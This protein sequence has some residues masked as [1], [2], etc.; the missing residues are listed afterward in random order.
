[1]G[2]VH[3]FAELDALRTERNSAIGEAKLWLR[4]LGGMQSE[5]DQASADLHAADKCLS[6]WQEAHAAQ[7]AHA[8]DLYA[9]IER[10]SDEV[11]ALQTRAVI[12]EAEALLLKYDVAQSLNRVYESEA[13]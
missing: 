3:P 6:E 11:F 5:R 9:T 2:T 10:L 1:M 12:L 8:A 7:R 4:R 13:A